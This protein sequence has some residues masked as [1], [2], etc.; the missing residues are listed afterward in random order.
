MTALPAWGCVR[1]AAGSILTGKTIGGI[2]LL[3]QK[4]EDEDQQSTERPGVGLEYY[5]GSSFIDAFVGQ[6]KSA[7]VRC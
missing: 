4:Y 3:V 2:V 6:A 1:V 5:E 7:T